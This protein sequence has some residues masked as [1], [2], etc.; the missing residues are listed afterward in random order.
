[1]VGRAS[2]WSVPARALKG[3]RPTGQAAKGRARVGRKGRNG[4][5]TGPTHPTTPGEG[6]GVGG[7]GGAPH[8]CTPPYMLRRAHLASTGVRRRPR[9]PPFWQDEFSPHLWLGEF[10]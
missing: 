1:M 8:R 6:V 7:P 3:G 9:R 4:E 2:P 10:K 5:R